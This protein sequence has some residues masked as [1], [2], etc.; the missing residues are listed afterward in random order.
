[1]CSICRRSRPARWKSRCT[2]DDIIKARYDVRRLFLPQAEEKGLEHRFSLIGAGLSPLA[3]LRSGARPAMRLQSSLQRD[4]V[5]RDGTRDDRTIGRGAGR[6][7]M[8][9]IRSAV[10]D[11]GI[12][13]TAGDDGE[14][15]S[16]SRRP[17]VRPTAF[18]RHRPRT[19]H[20]AAAG[21]ADGRRCHGRKRG[22]QGIDLH[23][24]LPRRRRERDRQ[25][26]VESRAMRSS[27]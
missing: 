4:E 18:R 26:L 19:D 9:M 17:T 2:D 24:Q 8:R 7:A 20:R 3:A 25:T 22:R 13:M 14:A 12:G 27:R 5:H 10:A 11:T 15:V 16:R 21:A 6:T 23:I 1:M